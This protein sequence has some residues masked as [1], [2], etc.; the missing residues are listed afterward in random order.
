VNGDGRPDLVVTPDQGGGP[1]VKVLSGDGFAT[2]ADFIAIGDPAF[3]GGARAA[4][5]DVTGDGAGDLILSAGSGG[6]PRVAG[7][8]GR[9]VAT[10]TPTPDKLFADFFA[11]EDSLRNGAYVAAG[12][13]NGDGFA[14]L[15]FG[16]GPGGGPRVAVLDGAAARGNRQ[17]PVSTFFAGD[18]DN[19]GGVPV[20]V[21][22]AAD[23]T[24]LVLAGAGAGSR[25]TG[26]RA[27]AVAG[28]ATPEAAIGFDAFPGF[29]GGVYVG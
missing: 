3:R 6:G 18:A 14:D 28:S 11:F 2:L 1:R 4:V 8:D 19:R 25:V 22:T 29:T 13:V 9:S 5:G 12:D 7:Y 21:G 17:V 20:A 26:Y 15:V 23:G 10:G 24:P 16:A 27:T